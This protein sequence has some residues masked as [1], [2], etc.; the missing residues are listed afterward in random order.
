VST[1]P[2][3]VK[4][5]ALGTTAVVFV[6]NGAAL[7]DARAACERIIADVDNACSRF[8]ADSDLTRVNENCGAWVSASSTLL[9]AIA[10]AIGAA[11]STDGLVD[12]TVGRA[13]CDMGYDRNF[14]DIIRTGV[15]PEV[16]VQRVPGWQCV[17]LD[18]SRG[19]VRVPSGVALDLGAT[20]KAWC[21]DRAANAA[22][23]VTGVGVAIGLGGD[24]AFVG[25][26]PIDGWRVRVTDD[27]R[28][29]MDEPEGQ[30]IS[31]LGGGLA[32]SGTSVRRWTRGDD[33][34]HHIIDPRRGQPAAAVWRTISVAAPSCT[35]ANI[36]ST[37][38]VVLGVD[39]PRWLAER[40]LPARLVGAAGSVI[41]VGG[42]P[43]P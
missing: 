8:R 5:D 43:S 36:A 10:V 16:R 39:A 2:D 35:Q 13:M 6:A 32:T 24:L 37:S 18:R 4:F 15:T 22:A 31:M 25:T 28:A 27:H 29:S 19:R 38:A 33:A 21:A 42:W 34:F 9:D 11:E 14:A 3:Q 26:P 41:Y 40:E 17:E 1:T 20:A 23:E 12:P 7:E 30:T